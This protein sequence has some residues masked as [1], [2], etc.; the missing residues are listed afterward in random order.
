MLTLG[1]KLLPPLTGS[2]KV[3]MLQLLYMQ[4]AYWGIAQ[5]FFWKVKLKENRYQLYDLYKTA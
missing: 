4:R 3:D 2:V 1:H 5:I